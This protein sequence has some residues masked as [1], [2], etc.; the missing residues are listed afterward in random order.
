[1]TR[2]YSYGWTYDCICPRCGKKFSINS[3][4]LVVTSFSDWGGER[5]YRFKVN[6]SD[7]EKLT[8]VVKK[9]DIPYEIRENVLAETTPI[10][11]NGIDW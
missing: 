6:C 8:T 5:F 7:C 11:D 4:D 2:I 10:I 9:D 3:R 1:M